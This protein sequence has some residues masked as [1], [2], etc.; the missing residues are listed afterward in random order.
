MQNTKKIN[1][2]ILGG[3][4]KF[5]T[6]LRQFLRNEEGIN[7]FYTKR[8][9]QYEELGNGLIYLN[10][11]DQFH[12]KKLLQ[13]FKNIFI[14]DLLVTRNPIDNPSIRD[15]YT[16]INDIERCVSICKLIE[17]CLGYIFLSTVAVHI[18]QLS[19]VTKAEKIAKDIISFIR[20]PVSIK[21]QEYPE[22]DSDRKEITRAPMPDFHTDLNL[23]MNGTSK[24]ISEQVFSMTFYELKIPL[25]IARPYRIIYEK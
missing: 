14:I 13:K 20:Y 6:Y 16:A 18:G 3:T 17:S 4:G 24:F 10:L 2:L 7:I 8:G 1:I 22:K 23:R 21:I 5:G 19:A 15:I 11:N 12:L 9:E 25:F